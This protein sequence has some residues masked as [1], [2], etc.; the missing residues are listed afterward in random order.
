MDSEPVH[1]QKG[2][3]VEDRKQQYEETV[4][5]NYCQLLSDL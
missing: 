4:I 2:H 5:F 3:L 1:E